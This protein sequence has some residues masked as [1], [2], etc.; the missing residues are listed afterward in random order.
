MGQEK[1]DAAHRASANVK[2]LIKSRGYTQDKFACEVLYIDPTTFR[3]WLT[4]G[5]TDINTIEMICQFFD[6]DFMTLLK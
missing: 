1:L 2:N 4:N 3:K 5:I 6:V